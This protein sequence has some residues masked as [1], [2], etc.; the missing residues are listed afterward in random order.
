MDKKVHL[1]NE[2]L[3]KKYKNNFDLVLHAIQMAEQMIKS[4]R[5]PRVKTQTENKAMIVIEEIAEG[6]DSL[7]EIIANASDDDLGIEFD[8]VETYV[9]EDAH[10]AEM[11]VIK[12]EE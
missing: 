12:E 1:T 11:A 8:H 3:A 9:L 10:K 4:G 6:R 5:G 7:D 2:F